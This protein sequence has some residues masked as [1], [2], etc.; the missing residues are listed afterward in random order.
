MATALF[1]IDVVLH[2]GEQLLTSCLVD[3]T[4]RKKRGRQSKT[5]RTSGEYAPASESLPTPSS[6]T[7][8]VHP[9]TPQ[10]KSEGLPRQVPSTPTQA[11]PPAK[12]TPK[13]GIKALPTVRDHTSDQLGPEGDEY[14]PREYDDAGEKKVDE[15]GYLND[16]RLYKPRTFTVP[17]R[18][19]KLF[20]LATECARVLTYR[21]SYLLFNKNR[22]LFK[23]IASQKEKED[24]IEK[25]VLP[26]SYRSR[27]IAI[28][29][30]RSMFRQFGSRVIQDGRRVRDD[31]WESK[32]R[33]QGFTEDDPAGEKRPGASRARQAAVAEPRVG[34]RPTFAHGDVVYSDGPAFEGM[35]AQALHLVGNVPQLPMLGYGDDSRFKDIARPRQEIS[36]PAYQDRI[37]S[38]TEA[39][40]M[41]QAA[42][43]AEFNKTV[44]QQRG[45]R[46]SMLEDYW[47]KPHDAPVTTPQSQP[48]ETV[49]AA[50]K[51]SAS[52]RFT[53]DIAPSQSALQ[54]QHR[55][56]SVP[57]M[58]PPAFHHQQSLTHSPL[59]Q[60][61]I[62]PNQLRDPSQFQHP[63]HLARS[64]SG[65]AMSQTPQLHPYQNFQQ[66]NPLHQGQQMWGNPP[67]QPQQSP[68]MNRMHTPHFSPSLG[69]QQVGHSSSPVPGQHQPSPSPHPPQMQ[70]PQLIN[71]QSSTGSMHGQQMYAGTQVMQ[72]QAGFAGMGQRPMYPM[73]GQG[74]SGGHFMPQQQPGMSGWPSGGQGQQQAGWPG[75]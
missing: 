70:P 64:S 71:H 53:S 35:Q 69:H 73:G 31:Y 50:V 66:H 18:G 4:R 67:P 37:S 63:S 28:V 16:G 57:Q 17:G 44:N 75:Y 47:H 8:P 42:H 52:P 11:S 55:D 15:L 58:N 7:S 34:V 48:V 61:S 43:T 74:Q 20:M 10:L 60:S 56:A 21:D 14:V 49:P 13:S 25:E 46:H 23:I 72:P 1:K 27:Q 54:H 26:F 68:V 30:A 19:N 6:Q 5:P 12:S 36:G 62:Q 51:Q 65:L 2:L 9:Q 3:E 41:N 29:T 24:L 22:S 38:S 39:E 40:I 45:F 33:K 32:A 59:R